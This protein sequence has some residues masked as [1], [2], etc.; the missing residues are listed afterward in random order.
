MS[1][2][3]AHI[4][5]KETL[6]VAMDHQR[7]LA[8]GIRFIEQ[9]SG[10][11]WTHY[12][13][14]DPGITVLQSLIYALVELSLKADLPI[15]DLMTQTEGQH[16]RAGALIAPQD[17]L[18]TSPITLDDMRRLLLDRMPDLRDV[19][20]QLE[21]QA[22]LPAIRVVLYPR[23]SFLDTDLLS[24]QSEP[25]QE[26]LC[27][28]AHQLLCQY[29]MEGQRFLYP[30]IKT[31]YVVEMQGRVELFPGYELEEYV[32]KLLFGLNQDLGSEANLTSL[33][34][35]TEAGD[36]YAEL[37]E[38]P[39]LQR[40]YPEAL[41]YTRTSVSELTWKE[42]IQ[43]IPGT[44]RVP[45]LALEFPRE[46]PEGHEV[47]LTFQSLE[48]MEFQQELTFFS[49]QQIDR[50][51][52]ALYLDQYQ[53][54][55][56]VSEPLYPTL[57]PGQ[58]HAVEEYHS[59]QHHMPTAYRLL[60]ATEDPTLGDERRGKVKQLKGFM[61][62]LEQVLADFLQQVASL[63]QVFEIRSGR[64]D[65]QLADAT[66]FTQ[67]LWSV[68]GIADILE[69]GLEAL[70]SLPSHMGP[71]EAWKEFTR[72]PLSPY[73]RR[74]VAG[75]ENKTT[76]LDRKG[77]MLEH[78]AARF[79]LRYTADHL[80]RIN[81]TYGEGITAKVWHLSQRLQQ[82]APLSQNRLR[83][84]YLLD[85]ELNRLDHH[86]EPE[87]EQSA[88]QQQAR[89][90]AWLASGV[91]RSLNDELDLTEYLQGIVDLIETGYESGDLWKIVRQSRKLVEAP[92]QGE[93]APD[94][95]YQIHHQLEALT[96]AF[97]GFVWLDPYRLVEWL[98]EPV[99]ANEPALPLGAIFPAYLWELAQPSYREFLKQRF[100]QAIPLG[101]T[102]QVHFEPRLDTMK[103]VL[104]WAQA[105]KR[106]LALQ[107]RS[108]YP[109][110]QPL[111]DTRQILT[112]D[113]EKLLIDA[114][115]AAGQLWHYLTHLPR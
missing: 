2:P 37:F 65:L 13:P 7:L 47:L 30:E 86:R 103:E 89:G 64:T 45:R 11:V 8:A 21:N 82:V 74:L 93:A 75:R 59:V 99:E 107:Y 57:P 112:L 27:A 95:Q 18:T 78:L 80:H 61:A 14:S 84:Y 79:G 43:S 102:V 68:P 66:Y 17:I 77:R 12:N 24:V 32:A 28:Q 41:P 34:A 19:H 49:L 9:Y 115:T 6:P 100:Y 58:Y 50:G 73:Y 88:A 3:A 96:Q 81:P 4:D 54:A 70:Q 94:V 62:L 114:T 87:A 108:T 56:S 20:L 110:L 67:G 44:R 29:G 25:R 101:Q 52:V 26:K 31:A 23:R 10:Q 90:G 104:F 111:H 51:R 109:L 22:P 36:S 71:A 63:P 85:T 97:R 106:G 1:Q 46:I 105:W 40:G 16:N 83:T 48:R 69:G 53:A 60:D 76:Q 42:Q 91:E 55:V 98:P 113:E 38:G 15:E 33:S 72:D 92:M 39:R 5:R 35:R